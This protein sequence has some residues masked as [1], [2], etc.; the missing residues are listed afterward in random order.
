[1]E[2]RRIRVWVCQ[3]KRIALKIASKIALKVALKVQ[4]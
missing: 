4:D 3:K 1:L 2:R